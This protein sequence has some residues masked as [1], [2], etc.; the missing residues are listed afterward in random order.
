[1]TDYQDTKAND[2]YGDPSGGAIRNLYGER[3]HDGD[4]IVPP[5]NLYDR[6]LFEG[7]TAVRRGW[8]TEGTA[9]PRVKPSHRAV[10]PLGPGNPVTIPAKPDGAEVYLMRLSEH[11]R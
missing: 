7:S 5:M 9:A 8:E 2:R 1:M 11:L 3:L 4:V 10:G 6:L